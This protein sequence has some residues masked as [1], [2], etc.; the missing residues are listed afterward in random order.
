MF[1]VQLKL[2]NLN[3]VDLQ[4]V[5]LPMAALRLYFLDKKN[6]RVGTYESYFWL[7]ACLVFVVGNT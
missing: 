7:F 5:V 2:G 4:A 1:K 3:N 6:G